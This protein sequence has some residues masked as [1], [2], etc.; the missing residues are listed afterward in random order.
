MFHSPFAVNSLKLLKDAMHE[1][2]PNF[3]AR[4]HFHKE[5]L[6]NSV[7]FISYHSLSKSMTLRVT[8]FLNSLQQDFAEIRFS[9][10]YYK[11][12]LLW[13]NL[14]MQETRSLTFFM[15]SNI[16]RGEKEKELLHSGFVIGPETVQSP[17][18]AVNLIKVYLTDQ[19]IEHYLVIYKVHLY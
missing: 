7:D 19:F 11:N 8:C 15:E 9:C 1:F 13:S 5:S 12:Q 4:L 14:T 16:F 17:D 2:F 18:S 6:F 3:L 10:L